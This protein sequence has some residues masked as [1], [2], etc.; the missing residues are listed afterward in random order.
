M[1]VTYKK[2]NCQ[3]TAEFQQAGQRNS[4]PVLL[5]A[6]RERNAPAMAR[7]RFEAAAA[8]QFSE[9]FFSSNSLGSY[10]IVTCQLNL[11]RL[12]TSSAVSVRKASV[13]EASRV[14]VS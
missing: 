5:A 7:Q 3:P 6:G 12:I 1:T 11:C 8:L 10:Y 14:S 4:K 9:Q 2:T 13:A